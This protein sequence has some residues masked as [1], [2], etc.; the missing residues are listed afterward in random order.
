[1]LRNKIRIS[2]N[3]CAKVCPVTQCENPQP[4]AAAIVV[5]VASSNIN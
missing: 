1:M 3:L 2:K 5:A 4:K